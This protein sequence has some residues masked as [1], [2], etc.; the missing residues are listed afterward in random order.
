VVTRAG[1]HSAARVG[2]SLLSNVG[3]GDLV[4][5]S[6]EAFGAIAAGLARDGARR[7]T[8]RRRLLDSP[9]GDAR[10][11]AERFGKALRGMW[12]AAVAAAL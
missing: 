4:A 10:G 9:L 11:F 6:D 5:T 1:R 7:G 2:V 12:R 3:L 8:L